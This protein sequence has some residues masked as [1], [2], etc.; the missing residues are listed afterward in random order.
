MNKL[1]TPRGTTWSVVI[2]IG[3]SIFVILQALNSPRGN[4]R[5]PRYPRAGEACKGEPIAVGY[6]YAGDLLGPH[7][8]KVQCGTETERYISYSDG[9]ATQCEPLPGCS[10]WGEDNGITCESPM[11]N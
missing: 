11:S 5:T 10:D 4:I 6:S 9:Q 2:L 7:E 8:C 1:Q 3:I